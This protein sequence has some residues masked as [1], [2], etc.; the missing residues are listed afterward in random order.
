VTTLLVDCYRRDAAWRMEFYRAMIRPHSDCVTVN[1]GV[2]GPDFDMSGFHSVVF[3]G[4]QIMLGEEDPDAA[5]VQFAR[6]L[7]VPGLGICFGHQLFARSFGATVLSGRLIER[8]ETV[9]LARPGRLFDGLGTEAR[10]L[11][12]HREFVDPDSVH[13]AGWQVFADSASCPVEAMHHPHLP[14]FGVQ[15][16]PERSGEPGKRLF[17]N[18]YEHVVLPFLARR[19]QHC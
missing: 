2:L 11:E 18:F 14:L 5:L 4:S 12:S 17:A 16:H 10:M 9:R 3:S 15:C 19:F 6:E 13:R 7:R 8:F 1:A